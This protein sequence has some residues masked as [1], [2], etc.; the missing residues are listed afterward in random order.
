MSATQSSPRGSLPS[1]PPAMRP[2]PFAPLA[3][4]L[5]L[6]LCFAA[7]GIGG[8][9]TTPEIDGWYRTLAKPSFSPPDWVFGPVW[10]VLYA[11]M[12]VV[13]WQIWRTRAP[14]PDSQAARSRALLA[15]IVQLMLNVSWSLVFF[16]LHAPTAALVV[17][18]LLWAAI[19]W[20]ILAARP[21]IGGFAYALLPYLAWV[22]FATAL[23]AAIVMLNG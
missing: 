3:L 15:F 8:A 4:V 12:G 18:V 10:T 2:R 21:V 6:A 20:T 11:I 22:S 23:N 19:V 17:I 9:V 7:A 16:G 14:T 5:C 1:E 13:L